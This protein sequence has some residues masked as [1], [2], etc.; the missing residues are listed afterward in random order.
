MDFIIEDGRLQKYTGPGG[1][2]EIPS[3][4]KMIGSNAFYGCRR[5]TAVSIPD[6][7]KRIDAKAFA[8]C[9]ALRSVR[10]GQGVQEIGSEA[11]L[12][13]R[14]L[15]A[16]AVPEGTVR[17]KT[18]AFAG[19]T[20][21]S[22]VSLPRS[23]R[24]LGMNAFERTAWFKAQKD[25]PV[26]AD[27]VFYTYKGE[28]PDYAAVSL[29][30]G[31]TLVAD[32]AF[33][34]R[35]GK[36]FF[37]S[38]PRSVRRIGDRAFFGSWV[39][40]VLL[41]Q[42]LTCIGEEAFRDCPRLA[43][44][45]L[46]PALT[47]IGDSAFM[48]CARLTGVQIPGGVRSIAHSA[49]F[50]CAALSSVRLQEG[51]HQIGSEVFSGCTALK[52]VAL[53]ESLREIGAYAFEDCTRLRSVQ[54]P[55]GIQRI[56]PDAF[57]NTG[58]YNTHPQGP[59]YAGAA[60]I[61]YKGKERRHRRKDRDDYLY[62]MYCGRDDDYDLDDYCD[63]QAPD[64]LDG[65]RGKLY[66]MRLEEVRD[67]G[68]YVPRTPERIEIRVRPGTT[69]IAD[70]A[71]SDNKNLCSV[72]LPEGVTRIGNAA[73]KG[74]FALERVSLPE[75]LTLICDAAFMNC[76]NLTEAV[77]PPRLRQIGV[78][79]FRSCI[80]LS[81][82]HL[83][84][85]LFRIGDSAFKNCV[86]L[87]GLSLPQGLRLLEDS[88]F[89]NCISLRR[90]SLPPNVETLGAR[91]FWGCASLEAFPAPPERAECGGAFCGLRARPDMPFDETLLRRDADWWRQ[92]FA[93]TRSDFDAPGA[94][95]LLSALAGSCPQADVLR[96]ERLYERFE[97]TD[98][99]G[100]PSVLAG[101][102]ALL[103]LNRPSRALLAQWVNDARD[104]GDAAATATLLGLFA[105]SR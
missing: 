101:F 55:R 32:G 30:A 82:V 20:R 90:V 43:D 42:E 57:A 93:C 25:G 74:C 60:L 88:A 38:L 76:V 105:G 12:E 23:L 9:E 96:D 10:F 56:C 72:T 79:A 86:R 104:R 85:S 15:D 47:E 2:A 71:L 52:S 102:L 1:D 66:L 18:R 28:M 11:F 29:R 65:A 27:S 44:V 7:V 99:P 41:P 50:E 61:A 37:V 54:L 64:E 67:C 80:K 95:A 51:V 26:Y 49:F 5:L 31:T 103:R 36:E 87:T 91:A 63:G 45:S 39:K 100:D 17:I 16:V 68:P 24:S 62:F 94:L 89:E 33:M 40:T 58:L 21:L 22:A 14:R 46:P 48:R 4:V 97:L 83:P 53:P 78:S 73:F 69:L 19:C 98:L 70:Q 84:Q 92:A 81:S 77:L 6:S 13:C 75:T 34:G 3:G 59:V 35:N 8:R